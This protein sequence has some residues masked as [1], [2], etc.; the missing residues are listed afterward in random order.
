[1][2]EPRLL[3]RLDRKK[4]QLDALH[5]LPAEAVRHLKQRLTVE[6]VY[7]S[8]AIAGSSLTLHNTQFILE[9]GLTVGGKSLREH[10]QVINQKAAIEYVEGLT[11]QANLITP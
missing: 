6:W 8:N 11:S 5:P 2:I 7:N 1:M 9:T 4:A 3:A 10:L